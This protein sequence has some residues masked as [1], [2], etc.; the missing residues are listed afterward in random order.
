MAPKGKNKVVDPVEEAGG[1]SE[2]VPDE[3]DSLDPSKQPK[4]GA[5]SDYLQADEVGAIRPRAATAPHPFNNYR[6]G[7]AVPVGDDGKLKVSSTFIVLLKPTEEPPPDASNEKVSIY[8][9]GG[10]QPQT[11]TE[12]IVTLG[13]YHTRVVTNRQGNVNEQV[14]FDREIF[15]GGSWYKCAIVRGHAARS[16]ILF[17]FDE[18]RGRVVP[19]KRY[20]LADKRQAVPLARMFEAVYSQRTRA[21]RA[22]KAFDNAQETTA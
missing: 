6:L 14:V 21:E 13:T 18:R 10:G 12:T 9:G 22:A 4:D 5:D 17:T 19:D 8:K 16:Q 3:F 11:G 7:R 2:Q 20:M 15:V 1:G